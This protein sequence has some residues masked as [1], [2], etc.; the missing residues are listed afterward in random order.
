MDARTKWM[1]V[2]SFCFSFAVRAPAQDTVQ[3]DELLDS[4]Q[5]W[6]QENVDNDVWDALGLDQSRVQ[7]FM[8]EL[9]RRFQG[10]D[11]YEL[12]NLQ[13]TATQLI[14]VLRK[15]EE[16]QPYALW[17]QSHLDYLTTANELRRQAR[18]GTN[19]P[20][21]TAQLQRR[22][23]VRELESRPLPPKAQSLMPR[24]KPVFRGESVPQ[25]LAWLA[26]VESSFNPLA[27]SPAGAVGLF[28]LMPATARRFKL[29]TSPRDERL[30][31][32][33]SA[34]A[35]ANYLRLL[36]T[37]FGDWRLALAAY[38]S[39]EQ[40]VNNLLRSSKTRSFD[41]IASRLPAETQMYVPKFE[42]VLLRRE[43]KTLINL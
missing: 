29:S 16:T 6:V 8:V 27:R 14:P 21:P 37:R 13:Q 18:P 33:K 9:Q 38:N 26:E 1:L 5:N 4:V 25:E 24:L 35:A 43:G 23:W 15:F 39:G 36:H 2:L 20:P 19:A 7:Q 32:E 28:Q 30:D 17:L 22:V 11:V 10:Q 42:A 40:R 41:A 12:G 34:R 3:A 31:P